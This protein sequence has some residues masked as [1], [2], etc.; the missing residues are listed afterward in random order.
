MEDLVINIRAN[1]GNTQSVLSG[2]SGGVQQLSRN[3]AGATKGL[4]G[5]SKAI[6]GIGQKGAQAGQSMNSMRYAMYDVSQTATIAGAALT[7]LGVAAVATGVA[8]ERDFA[9]VV[10]TAFDDFSMDS[11]GSE[12]AK[13]KSEFIGLQQTLPVTSKELSQIGML[14]GQLGIER[15]GIA[16]FTEVVAQMGATSEITSEQFGTFLG[17]ANALLSD[18][19]PSRFRDL[20]DAISLVGVNSVATETQIVNI[21]TQISSMGTFAKLGADQIVGISG[22]LASVGAQPEISRGTITRTFSLMSKAVGEGGESLDA[23][24]RIAGMSS[25]E[26]SRSWGEQGNADFFL[27]FLK[28]IDAEGSNAVQALNDLG[29]RSVRDVPLLMRLANA[30]DVVAKSFADAA[31]GFEGSGTLADQ[32]GVI[33]ETVASKIQLLGNNFQALIVTLGASSQGPIA[34]FLDVLTSM[35]QRLTDL[36]SNPVASWVF[37]IVAAFTV[38]SGIALLAFGSITRFAASLMALQGAGIAALSPMAAI[39]GQLTAM[40]GTSAAAARG[41]GLLRAGM[42]ALKA[43]LGILGAVLIL[44]ELGGWAGRQLDAIRGVDQSVSGSMQTMR[45]EIE[46]TNRVVYDGPNTDFSN[47]ENFMQRRAGDSGFTKWINDMVYEAELGTSKMERAFQRMDK[48]MAEAVTAGDGAALSEMTAEMLKMDGVTFDNLTHVFPSLKR[49]LDGA[50]LSMKQLS[51]G[52]VQLADANG[53]IITSSGAV[54]EEMLAIEGAA[55]AEAAAM[56]SLAASLGM[57]ADE[58]QAFRDAHS[59]AMDSFRGGADVLTGTADEWKEYGDAA[60]ASMDA[61]EERFGRQLEGMQNFSTNLAVLRDAGFAEAAAYAGEQGM[62]AGSEFAQQ[63]AQAIANGDTE[64]IA[65]IQR[66]NDMLADQARQGADRMGDVVAEH[67]GIIAQAFEKG[68]LDGANR[69][70]QALYDNSYDE[71]ASI[72]SELGMLASDNPIKI[73][74]NSDQARQKLSDVASDLIALDAE[75]ANPDVEVD[76]D[77]AIRRIDSAQQVLDELDASEADPAIRAQ[78]DAA[79]R[80][81]EEMRRQVDATDRKSAN[82]RITANTGAALSAIQG[83]I[84]A[85]GRVRD[86]TV[87]IRAT[88][89]AVTAPGA[90]GTN[91]GTS[92]GG[93]NIAF[94]TGGHVAGRGTGVSDSIPAYLSNGEYVIR[95]AAARKHGRAF[96]DALNAGRSPKFSTG[97]AVGTASIPGGGFGGP[98]ELGPKTLARLGGGQ[99]VTVYLSNEQIASA[100]N[101]GNGDSRRRGQ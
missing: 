83:V 24:A 67:S 54:S 10:R 34:L 94:S 6:D 4:D 47:T 74:A 89:V 98:M 55:D 15:S 69:L 52:S 9:N 76:P 92:T 59:S 13:L 49:A 20:A 46:K 32:Y 33:A 16:E 7:A 75:I 71:V 70:T 97:G 72:L 56:E 85:I 65:Q 40:A 5:A 77:E 96:L 82:P 62:G 87:T 53:D 26:F 36:A 12:V 41:V 2:I 63:M 91:V 93:G 58:L 22:A 73:D 25:A 100:A 19:D 50:G 81:L 61:I 84:N 21:A 39:N 90:T 101:S 79:R 1:A 42:V 3:T 38:L 78:I 99:V 64:A 14:A 51:D 28:G 31:K 44:P 27:N 60:I 68:G 43:A 80:N 29:I 37:T 30:G 35:L 86:K 57:T 23:F 48:A 45:E 11:F 95:A 88:T 17:R 18:V 8:W 66:I